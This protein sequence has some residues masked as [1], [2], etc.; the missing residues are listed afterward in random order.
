MLMVMGVKAG[1][2]RIGTTCSGSDV[3]VVAVSGMVLA[4]ASNLGLE[5]EHVFSVELDPGKRA[6]LQRCLKTSPQHV[7]E[8]VSIFGQ[9]V[10]KNIQGEDVVIADMKVDLVISGWSCKDHSL[11]NVKQSSFAGNLEDDGAELGGTSRFTYLHGVKAHLL[12][13]ATHPAN[14][15][16][17]AYVPLSHEVADTPTLTLIQ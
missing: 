10:A 13:S 7:F 17:L 5:V 2:F 15:I 12:T 6:F 8:C 9:V 11:C 16:T 14:S 4:L 3:G 1:K